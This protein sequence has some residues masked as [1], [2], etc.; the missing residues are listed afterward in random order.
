MISKRVAGRKD[1]RS[2]ASA[3]LRYG[4]GLNIDRTTGHYIDKAHRIRLGGFGLIEN[5][6]YVDQPIELI[7]ALIDLAALEMQANSEMN[8]RVAAEN[9]IAHF[10]FGFDQIR[11]TDAVLRDVEDST[12]SALKLQ[13]NHFATFLHN[14]NGHWHLHFFASRIEKEKPHRGNSLWR[15][16]TLRDQICRAVEVR[17]GLRRDNGLHKIDA[18]G[19][20]VEIPMRERRENRNKK[21][22]TSGSARHTEIITGTKSFQT[23]CIDIRI[24]DQ[25][26]HATSWQEIHS[27]AAKYAIEVKQKGAG[28]VICPLDGKGGMELSRVG[29]KG[30]VARFGPFKPANL[31][32][33]STVNAAYKQAPTKPA[34]ELYNKWNQARVAHDE[35]KRTSVSMF[36][37]TAGKSRQ[38]LREQHKSELATIRATSVGAVQGTAISIKK[39]EHSS[40]L[41]Q[42]AA[43]IR[44]QRSALYKQL[45]TAAPGATFR[46][47]LQQQG[48][49]GDDAALELARQYGVDEATEVFRKT[50]IIKL[51][52]AA[53]I[54]GKA[55]NPV[56][57]PSIRHRIEHNGTIVFDLGHGRVV[58]DSA[59]SKQIQLNAA[60]ANDPES[61]ETSLRFATSRFGRVLSLSGSPEFQRLAVETAVR[62]RLNVQFTDLAL[63]EYRKNFEDFIF[64]KRIQ[65]VHHARANP[66]RHILP[67][68]SRDRVQPLPAR[69]VVP[70]IQDLEVLLPPDVSD[71]VGKSLPTER[72]HP[73]LR[74]PAGNGRG[75][76]DA[77]A[78]NTCLPGADQ[79]AQGETSTERDPLGRVTEAVNRS[80]R[81]ARRRRGT[82]ISN[83]PG[84]GR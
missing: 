32:A 42:L 59:I 14:D 8:S 19:E 84:K 64:Q 74:R 24:G 44:A 69:A 6:I 12:L 25:L 43:E 73:E 40:A 5:G 68:G 23:W 34:T 72:G 60:A 18:N 4:A 78:S 13:N 37:E 82:A 79:K 55:N 58:T 2:S 15:D 9:K 50:E 33:V 63:E 39:M 35:L 21:R 54:S 67:P 49:A 1:G 52:I 71:H 47:Y 83:K 28:F 65:Y 29:L 31:N 46:T 56:T 3:A 48:Q 45:A 22:E 70:D 17:Y 11:P 36:R 38:E 41:T 75:N 62:N 27:I 7:S 66:A 81:T 26:R 53:A 10:L 20:I 57:R 30:L 76:G 51:Q 77:A 16:K 80:S 61:I